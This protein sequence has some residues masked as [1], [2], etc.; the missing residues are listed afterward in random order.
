MNTLGRA[1]R[2]ALAAAFLLSLPAALAAAPPVQAGPV[3]RVGAGGAVHAAVFADGGFVVVWSTAG[4]RAPHAQTLHA[5]IYGSK[6]SPAGP[7]LEILRPAGQVVDSVATLADGGFVVA[8]EQPV[9]TDAYSVWARVW[10]RDGSPRSAPFRTHTSTPYDH[11]CVLAAPTP[12]G[13]FVLEWSA[14]AGTGQ[15]LGFTSIVSSR[16]YGGQGKPLSPAPQEPVLRPIFA[17]SFAFV[18]ALSVTPDGAVHD[19]FL[20][21]GDDV[22]IDWSSSGGVTTNLYGHA[23]ITDADDAAGYDPNHVTAGALPGGGFVLAWSSFEAFDQLPFKIYV[24]PFTATGVAQGDPI[25]IDT[26]NGR[27]IDPV[28]T[29]LPDG[30]FAVLWPELPPSGTFDQ[31]TLYGRL[32]NARGKPATQ[33]FLLS[34]PGAGSQAGESVAAGSDGTVIAVWSQDGD[35]TQGGVFA[36]VLR[37]GTGR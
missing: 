26:R 24:Q 7:E 6:G 28:V 37:T 12:S 31:G 19:V 21:Q 32:F 3:L 1:R 36:R 4:N 35:G 16:A 29:G 25:R 18:D 30:G 15:D 9:T 22:T 13:G 2:V 27:E 17:D 33:E 5:R 20:N 14:F 10:N 23:G 11:C 8:W 34:A